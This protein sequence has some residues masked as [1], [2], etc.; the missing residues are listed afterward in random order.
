MFGL[1]AETVRLRKSE[2]DIRATEEVGVE[3]DP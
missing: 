1:S 2:L 3:L